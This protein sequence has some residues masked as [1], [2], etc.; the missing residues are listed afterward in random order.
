MV[1]LEALGIQGQPGIETAVGFP[2]KTPFPVVWIP[3]EDVE[4]PEDDL[5][6]QAADKGAA[7]FTRG[8]GMTFDP[9]NGEVFFCCT[10]GGEK[11]LGQIWRYVPDVNDATGGNIELFVEPND[12][13]VLEAPDNIT[14]SPFG[15]LFTCEDGSGTDRLVGI[16]P[17]GLLYEF[18][19]NNINNNELAGVTFSPDGQTM[20]FNIQDPGI[21]FA[22]WGPWQ[23]VAQ[24][25][26]HRA[27]LG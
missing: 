8:E 13:E 6:K 18:I 16:T 19:Q 14:V 24:L 3:L 4:S 9:V 25:S 26:R 11:K 21:T 20:F 7:I 15:D 27:R 22:V 17:D 12:K 2:L 1:R 10:N 5:R 23:K